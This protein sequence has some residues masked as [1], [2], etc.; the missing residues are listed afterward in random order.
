MLA[1]DGAD[2][3][4]DEGMRAG[5]KGERFYLFDSK[6]GD[7]S[8]PA[9]KA[10][11]RPWSVGAWSYIR[12]TSRIPR[13]RLRTCADDKLA[14]TCW[15]AYYVIYWQTSPCFKKLLIVK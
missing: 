4:L 8:Q 14:V 1:T 9:V 5:C 12:P 6:D 13:A 11:K 10:E 15:N 7:N 3:M 2:Q